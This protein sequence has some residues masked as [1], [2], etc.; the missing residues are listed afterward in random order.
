MKSFGTY[1]S[2]HLASLAAFI[3]ILLFLN[4]IVFGITFHKS[5]T[6]DYGKASPRVMLETAAAAAAPTGISKEA[7]QELPR[8]PRDILPL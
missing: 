5:F 6:E 2:K 7:G 4:A 1:I 3:F 8:F